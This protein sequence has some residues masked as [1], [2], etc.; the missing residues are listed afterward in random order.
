MD[1][2]DLVAAS[3]AAALHAGL[4]ES[5][6]ESQITRLVLTRRHERLRKA[7]QRASRAPSSD[8]SQKADWLLSIFYTLY[9]EKTEAAYAVL[10]GDRQHIIR[11]LKTYTVGQLAAYLDF[12]LGNYDAQGSYREW[13]NSAG[14]SIRVFVKSVPAVVLQASREDVLPEIVAAYQTRWEEQHGRG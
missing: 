4:L 9:E 3:D 2:D 14:P 13:V 12:F 10:K 6:L 1:V 8:D 7:K 11:L 5:E